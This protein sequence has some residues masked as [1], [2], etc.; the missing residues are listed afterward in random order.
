[1]LKNGRDGKQ[2]KESCCFWLNVSV[3]CKIFIFFLSLTFPSVCLLLPSPQHWVY[4]STLTALPVPAS[5]RSNQCRIIFP[6]CDTEQYWE[7]DHNK[8]AGWGPLWRVG[9]WGGGR[10][11]QHNIPHLKPHYHTSL[12]A[13]GQCRFRNKLVIW[14]QVDWH[15]TYFF[16]NFCWPFIKCVKQNMDVWEQ[17]MR[18][19]YT[20]V[21]PARVRQR[22]RYRPKVCPCYVCVYVY[23]E[24]RWG[25]FTS[26][27]SLRSPDPNL[28][29]TFTICIDS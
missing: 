25:V 23:A 11:R 27:Q 14:R 2:D 3:F 8:T 28:P 18:L 22:Q 19:S 15:Q 5:A 9:E 21:L 4:I 10:H 12:Q 26:E 20:F 1:M 7:S 13:S 16:P 29:F 6:P 24:R 17:V